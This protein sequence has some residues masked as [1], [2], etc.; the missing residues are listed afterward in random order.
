MKKRLRLNQQHRYALINFARENIEVPIHKKALDAAYDILEPIVLEAVHKKFPIEHMKI[1]ERYGV[2]QQDHCIDIN[3]GKIKFVFPKD[4]E[5]NSNAPLVPNR[6][7]C[8]DRN[9]SFTKDQLLG[10]IAKYVDARASYEVEFNEKLKAYNRLIGNSKYLE[11]VVE[12]WPAAETLRSQLL[13]PNNMI[14]NSMDSGELEMI[15]DDNAG[16]EKKSS[17]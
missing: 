3:S 9:Y 15:K 7:G 17:S 10:P 5:G 16:A 6:Y 11:E 1:L 4:F 2:A 14:A 12:F 8:D 13:K